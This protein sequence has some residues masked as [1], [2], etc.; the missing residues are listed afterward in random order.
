MSFLGSIETRLGGYIGL[1]FNRM[2]YRSETVVIHK[3]WT[4]SIFWSICFICASSAL[5]IPLKI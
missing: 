2:V 3:D 5:S 1:S 4:I